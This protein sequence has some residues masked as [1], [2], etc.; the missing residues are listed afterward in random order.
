MAA[1]RNKTRPTGAGVDTF[2]DA[3][4]NERRREDARTVKAMM[5]RITGWEPRM[6]GPSIVG[7]GEYH[8]RYES[9]REGDFLITGFSPRKKALTIY[10]MPGFARYD[11]LMARLGKFRTGRSCLYI[12]KLDDVDLSVLEEL[13]ASSV[14][15]MVGKY[16][17]T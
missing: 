10:I 16:G 12:N 6:W 13:I 7:F 3:V 2:L 4:E 1:N 15:Y 8:Y 9:G 17:V 14:Q 11:A 5:E